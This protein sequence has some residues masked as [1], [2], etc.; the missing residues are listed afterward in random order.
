MS[1]EQATVVVPTLIILVVFASMYINIWMAKRKVQEWKKGSTIWFLYS[2]G[3]GGIK[4]RASLVWM[5]K[6]GYDEVEGLVLAK[7]QSRAIFEAFAGFF[8]VAM[9]MSSMIKH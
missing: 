1:P 9:L 5:K 8:V 4:R 7:Y 3:T 2:T 6:L